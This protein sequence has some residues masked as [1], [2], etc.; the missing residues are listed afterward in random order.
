MKKYQDFKIINNAKIQ[1]E[2]NVFK[3]FIRDHK[4]ID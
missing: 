4:Q 1:H 2:V 3:D